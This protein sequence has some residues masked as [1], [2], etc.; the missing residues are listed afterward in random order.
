M[1]E[2]L[3]V[4]DSESSTIRSLSITQGQVKAVKALVGGARDPTVSHIICNVITRGA[5]VT[6]LS[7]FR[8]GYTETAL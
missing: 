7:V 6:P 8:Q 4:A 5:T 1:E 3:F 2:H